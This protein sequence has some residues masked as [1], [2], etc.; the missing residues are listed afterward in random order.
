MARSGWWDA[1]GKNRHK[2]LSDQLQD[3]L[4]AWSADSQGF[5]FERREDADE[6]HVDVR[7]LLYQP[8]N[9]PI[10]T[11]LASVQPDKHDAGLVFDSFTVWPGDASHPARIAALGVGNVAL[12]NEAVPPQ[13]FAPLRRPRP[14]R[15]E[16]AGDPHVPT[17]PPPPPLTTAKVTVTTTTTDKPVIVVGRDDG[18][19]FLALNADGPRPDVLAWNADGS[20]LFAAG[21]NKPAGAAWLTLATGKR[22]A[23]DD[24]PGPNA[25][26]RSGRRTAAMASSR[27]RASPRPAPF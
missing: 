1:S 2:V 6:V 11:V 3:R 26:G 24:R 27:T 22:M 20:H 16:P 7:D 25:A 21:A 23:L 15:P 13:S 19:P 8:L 5:Y 4:I 18:T 14:A 9:G 10:R 12:L 17:P